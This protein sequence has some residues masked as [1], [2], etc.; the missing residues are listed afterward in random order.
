MMMSTSPPLGKRTGLVWMLMWIRGF[1]DIG[2][3]IVFGNCNLKN[4]QTWAK[5]LVEK[6]RMKLVRCSW[7]G[8]EF[9][10]TENQTNTGKI[11][12][13][14]RH[15]RTELVS[16]KTKQTRAKLNQKQTRAKLNQTNTGKILKN[17]L[18]R[19]SG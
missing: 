4:K 8:D 16:K 7:I 13:T 5:N 2:T 14:T 1:V 6:L 9:H 10:L 17:Y 3:R 19:H 15:Q 12:K 11:R 18:Q